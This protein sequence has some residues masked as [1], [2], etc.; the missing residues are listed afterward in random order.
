MAALLETG[1]RR[2][3]TQS[4][5]ASR[6]NMHGF[7]SFG[8]PKSFGRQEST[9]SPQLRFAQALARQMP[10]RSFDTRSFDFH[11]GAE[12]EDD[13][14]EI[15]P[16]PALGTFGLNSKVV[17]E[18]ELSEPGFQNWLASCNGMLCQLLMSLLLWILEIGRPFMYKFS[19]HGVNPAD[20]PLPGVLILVKCIGAICVCLIG[21]VVQEGRKGLR[22][23]CPSG[24]TVK[25]IPLASLGTI[26][27]FCSIEALNNIDAGTF[28]MMLHLN[29][30]TTA[31]V[32]CFLLRRRYSMLQVESLIIVLLTACIFFL[33][34]KAEFAAENGV[35][36]ISSEEAISRII[37]WIGLFTVSTAA[38]FTGI[39]KIGCRASFI[40]PQTFVLMLVL[41]ATFYFSTMSL[42]VSHGTPEPQVKT[43]S[44]EA[45]SG[46]FIYG[47]ILTVV[48]VMCGSINNV[49]GEVFL[50]RDQRGYNAQKLNM[51]IA[52]MPLAII[53]VL[54]EAWYTNVDW[55][56][57]GPS[58]RGWLVG[59]TWKVWFYAGWWLVLG[60]Y[61]GLFIKKYSALVKRLMQCCSAVITY[62]ISAAIGPTTPS[63]ATTL[64]ALLIIEGVALY[65]SSPKVEPDWQDKQ[66][67]G[68]LQHVRA[69]TE[70]SGI[71]EDSNDREVRP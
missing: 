46:S 26:A 38:V 4:L 12:P 43:V 16:S 53:S 1:E 63:I 17:E 66:S 55:V 22:E 68:P 23:C 31:T 35:T 64:S 36:T 59:W 14:D 3:R 70:I 41:A 60:W 7:D 19:T 69:N 32:S 11:E 40:H 67:P 25:L 10:A 71:P 13:I 33:N 45:A 42:S 29:I 50:M 30:I 56:V 15:L 61:A 58:M 27:N 65:F 62:G 34:R 49:V 20:Y 52:S 2:A 6:R 8:D 54:P 9:G 37:F 24:V 51:E 5:P 48:C 28:K 39:Y 18:I 47:T 44:D 21:S 57:E